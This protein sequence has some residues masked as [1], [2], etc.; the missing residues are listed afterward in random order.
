[1]SAIG[2]VSTAGLIGLNSVLVKPTRSIGPFTAQITV[3]EQ[4]E[5]TLE[6][7]DHPVEQGAVISD[8]AFK[9]P[10]KLT[11][12]VGWSNSP[13]KA[14][15]VEGL[16]GAATSTVAGA[17][18][19]LSG[20]SQQQ[21]RDL[22]AKLLKLQSDAIPFEIF[23]GKRRYSDMLIQSISTT[24]EKNTE[25]ILMLTLS[26]RQ[27]IIVRTSVV[28]V[29]ADMA[30]QANPQ[31]TAA[32]TQVGTRALQSG[33]TFSNAGAGRGFINPPLAVP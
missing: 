10:A 32:P 1:M 2:Y 14:G 26:C 25:N 15:L 7:T 27:V 17:Q 23:T 20:N 22:Y 16:V 4:H 12:E 21:V 13:S 5:D 19:I 31:S 8:H 28:L 30:K 29:P 9:M 24:T 3:K 33:S 11:L 18:S 6:I